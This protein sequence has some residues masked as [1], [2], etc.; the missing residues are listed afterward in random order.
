MWLDYGGG[1]FGSGVG[2]FNLSSYFGPR[3]IAKGDALTYFFGFE[4]GDVEIGWN[5]HCHDSCHE[6]E[7]CRIHNV[8]VS[9]FENQTWVC[10]DTNSY[11]IFHFT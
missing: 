4:D 10:V 3:I 8:L 2:E 7:G 6:Q 9:M 11:T 1:E 5:E